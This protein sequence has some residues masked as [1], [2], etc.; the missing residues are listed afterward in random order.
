MDVAAVVLPTNLHPV[1]GYNRFRHLSLSPR[2]MH[3]AH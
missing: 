1:A 3:V 2:A